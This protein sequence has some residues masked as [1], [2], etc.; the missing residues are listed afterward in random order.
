MKNKKFWII[1][2][3]VVFLSTIAHFR[4]DFSENAI[5]FP[6]QEKGELKSSD[7]LKEILSQK[8]TY[9]SEGRQS[10]VFQSHDEKYVLKF[11][12]RK[13][14][15]IPWYAKLFWLP[16]EM[17]EKKALRRK[18][19]ETSYSLAEKF[20]K[21]ETALLCVHL[22]KSEGL[23]KLFL[24]DKAS[25]DFS[26]NLNSVPFILQKKGMP[27]SKMM[28]DLDTESIDRLSSEFV[29]LVKKRAKLGIQDKDH[30]IENN[31]GY[32]EGQL[33][34]LDPGRLIQVS[35]E[36]SDQA[37]ADNLRIFKKWVKKR[38]L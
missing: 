26:I 5:S 37:E 15:E 24:K 1:S 30:D 22:Q 28:Q 36:S 19:F 25:R 31:Y 13:Y 8:F 38:F 21:E 9:L 4:A 16:K 12:K 32:I 14:M 29:S 23:P 20:L 33:F 17:A 34:H 11:F 27:L 2:L 7:D 35:E 18:F 6:L 3:L 10:Y